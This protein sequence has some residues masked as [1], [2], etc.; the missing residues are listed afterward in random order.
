[1]FVGILRDITERKRAEE[2]IKNSRQEYRDLYHHL[3]TVR[4][5]ERTRIS[6]ELHDELGGMLT[7]LKIDLSWLRDKLPKINETLS[8]KIGSMLDFLDTTIQNVQRISA[9]LRPSILDLLDL[10][11]AIDWQAEEFQNRTGIHCNLNSDLKDITMDPDGTTAVFRILHETLTNV[12]R[13]ARASKVNIKL[14]QVDGNLILEVKDNGIGISESQISSSKSL[15]LIGIRERISLLEGKVKIQG[16]E[17]KGTSVTISI[18]HDGRGRVSV[19][20]QPK[21]DHLS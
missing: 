10:S 12:A 1:M 20:R 18:P 13:Y 3:Q 6:R 4:E 17:G 16:T 11:D 19:S 8:R 14:N 5:K 9:D 2:E 15:G 21:L 7:V